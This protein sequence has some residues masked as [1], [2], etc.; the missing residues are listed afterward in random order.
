M[1]VH[2][3][4]VRVVYA[5]VHRTRARVCVHVMY[6]YMH[7]LRTQNVMALKPL[8]SQSHLIHIF[9]PSYEEGGG[10]NL[11]FV[12]LINKLGTFSIQTF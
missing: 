12:I 9:E 3:A 1:Y 4:R 11:Y 8:L 10:E 7:V 2:R 6:V 5:H